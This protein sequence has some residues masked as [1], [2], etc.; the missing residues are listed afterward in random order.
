M[1]HEITRPERQFN[2][3]Q[4]SSSWRG[5]S[6][7]ALRFM[8]SSG[9]HSTAD[10]APGC[11]LEAADDEPIAARLGRLSRELPTD[12]ATTR[13]ANTLGAVGT[14]RT[15]PEIACLRCSQPSAVSFEYSN[16][17]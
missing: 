10:F 9:I 13:V 5:C 4:T 11:A 1:P 6:F 16:R 17:R 8:R 7:E 12:P 2:R 3:Q 15:W 14:N